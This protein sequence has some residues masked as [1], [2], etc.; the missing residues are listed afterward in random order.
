MTATVERPR[1]TFD[2]FQAATRGGVL[3][4]RAV[5]AFFG[6]EN[7]HQFRTAG[8]KAE[9]VSEPDKQRVD[10]EVYAKVGLELNLPEDAA[11]RLW[12]RAME[13]SNSTINY[14]RRVLFADQ[15]RQAS[16]LNNIAWDEG[17]PSSALERLTQPTRLINEQLRYEQVRQ[18]GL[19]LLCAEVISG[20][21][22][23]NPRK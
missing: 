1:L 11:E 4:V 5:R 17:R 7:Y 12:K 22:N 13:L 10:R 21:E 9:E 8:K 6:S 2:M 16:L 15:E 3:V 20:D 23:G 14:A 19:A 18:L